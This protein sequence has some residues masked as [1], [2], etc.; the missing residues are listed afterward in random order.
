MRHPEYMQIYA[1]RMD[2]IQRVEL[3][4]QLQQSL[5]MTFCVKIKKIPKEY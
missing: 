4:V 5:K 1:H 2:F 3:T